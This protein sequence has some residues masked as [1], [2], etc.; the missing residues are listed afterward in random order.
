[1]PSSKNSP[2][3][4]TSTKKPTE[5]K[6]AYSMPLALLGS[7]R[8][9]VRNLLSR[10]PHRSF[11]RTYRRDYVRSLK[12]PGYWSFTGQVHK[13]LWQN[14]K[15]FGLLVFTYAALTAILVGLASQEIYE[16]LSD[17]L[18]SAGENAITGD[19]GMVGNAFVLLGSGAVGALNQ[20]PTESQQIFAAILG[21]MAWLTTV[22]LLRALMAGGKPKLRDGLYNAA[23]PFL[24]TLLVSF[25]VVLQLLPVAL[26]AIGFSAASATGLF[27]GGVE[28]MVFWVGAGMLGMLSLYWITS[29]LIALVVITLPGMYP[30]QALRT[31]GDL[32]VGRRIRILLRIAWMLLLVAVAWVVVVVPV[33]LF[34][35]WLKSLWS[36][37]AW[38]P[39]VPVT[40]LGMASLTVLWG[41]AYIYILYRKV[42]DDDAAPA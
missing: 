41:A 30:L 13:L 34:D 17:S 8:N 27:D 22:W 33:I 32:V 5:D 16:E 11:R 4:K 18:F 19:L 28:A 1:M 31:A 15:L 37:V 29:S 38:L 10:R 3:K 35:S 2:K 14:K 20:A 42:V 24:S 23:A 26:A 21:L 6:K 12:L 7:W 36:A 39:I 40:M 9:R 25:V